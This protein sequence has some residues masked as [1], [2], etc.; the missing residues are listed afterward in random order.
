MTIWDRNRKVFIYI[1]LLLQK[2]DGFHSYS[3]NTKLNIASS[4]CETT[5]LGDLTFTL[6]KRV[7]WKVKPLSSGLNGGDGQ[8]PVC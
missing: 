6:Q 1:Y 8:H 2:Q 5:N 7:R 4:D 3:Q